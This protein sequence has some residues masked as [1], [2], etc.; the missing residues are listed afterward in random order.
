MDLGP[1]GSQVPPES[2]WLGV[3]WLLPCGMV[4][5]SDKSNVRDKCLFTC[6]SLRTAH[7][8]KSAT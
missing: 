7:G 3:C 5:H 4:K 2:A 1:L 8:G 6:L